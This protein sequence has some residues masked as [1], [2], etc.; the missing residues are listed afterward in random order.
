MFF[1]YQMI[2]YSD[3]VTDIDRRQQLAQFTMY[4]S[5]S[6]FG[7]KFAEWIIPTLKQC[8]KKAKEKR[9]SKNI[10]KNKS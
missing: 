7:V 8:V 3:F 9:E 1:N 6:I 4:F 5:Y 2:C 10:Q